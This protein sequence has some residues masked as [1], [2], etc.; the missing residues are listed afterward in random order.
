MGLLSA[1]LFPVPEHTPPN[2]DVMIAQGAASHAAHLER[3]QEA[4]N[5]VQQLLL[6]QK[7]P[8][9]ALGLVP[10]FTSRSSN[11]DD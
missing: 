9:S 10:S 7:P 1:S 6:T 5:A 8:S 2:L 4:T 11:S 3:L